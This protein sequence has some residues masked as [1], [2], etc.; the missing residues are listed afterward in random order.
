MKAFL[1]HDEVTATQAAP[2][3][4]A[5]GFEIPS[6][7][8]K[9]KRTHLLYVIN[10]TS[11]TWTAAFEVW[12]HQAKV[13]TPAAPQTPIAGGWFRLFATGTIAV[14][15]E[16]RAAVALDWMQDFDRLA[17][18]IPTLSGTGAKASALI[19]LPGDAAH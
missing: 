17:V 19:G 5:D 2:T 10:G 1:I 15:S 8:R 18:A 4:A 13:A 11:G 3:L 6:K 16:E 14:T 9:V 12:A 7:W